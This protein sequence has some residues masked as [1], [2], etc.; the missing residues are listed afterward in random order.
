MNK[1][2]RVEFN[3][4]GFYQGQGIFTV[5][6]ETAEI[7]ADDAKEAIDL[8]IDWMV[9]NDIDY[10]NIDCDEIRAKYENYAWIAY[11]IINGEYDYRKP[12]YRT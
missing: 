11:E 2:F 10:G 12:L 9:E 3:E 6:D 1:M 4:T 5:L 8:C 7:T